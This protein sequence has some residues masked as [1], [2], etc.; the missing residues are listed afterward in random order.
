MQWAV[1][2]NLFQACVCFRTNFECPF[3][4]IGVMQSSNN[5]P[6]STVGMAPLFTCLHFPHNGGESESNMD[7]NNSSIPG[8]ILLFHCCYCCM[9]G[10]ACSWP[11]ADWSLRGSESASTKLDLSLTKLSGTPSAASSVCTGP[12]LGVQWR[13]KDSVVLLCALWFRHIGMWKWQCC[14]S[15]LL[16]VLSSAVCR[17]S[18][19]AC[20]TSQY[21]SSD[22]LRRTSTKIVS[23]IN[24]RFERNWPP[25]WEEVLQ[26]L[27]S[28]LWESQ[29]YLGWNRANPML[30]FL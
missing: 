1:D 13:C 21:R 24:I 9:F 18:I 26:I 25:L 14:A 23:Q 29:V 4:S 27:C 8:I 30:I 11:V 3:K 16:S 15:R 20:Y 7:G 19:T 10:H 6:S 17:L 12:C 28:I 22:C 5:E 2:L